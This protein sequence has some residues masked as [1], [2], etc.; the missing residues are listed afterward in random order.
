MRQLRK[1]KCPRNALLP[2]NV[3][4]MW[5]PHKLRSLRNFCSLVPNVGIRGPQGLRS[6]RPSPLSKS[7]VTKR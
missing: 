6:L 2:K 5:Q 3:A 7:A 4:A 1:Q